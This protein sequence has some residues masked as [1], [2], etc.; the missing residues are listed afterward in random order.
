MVEVQHR[1][2]ELNGPSFLSFTVD[3]TRGSGGTHFV[4]ICKRQDILFLGTAISQNGNTTRQLLGRPTSRLGLGSSYWDV[5]CLM[6]NAVSSGRVE[7]L[8]DVIKYEF[9]PE[10]IQKWADELWELAN[11]LDQT[12]NKELSNAFYVVTYL[13]SDQGIIKAG[14]FDPFNISRFLADEKNKKEIIASLELVLENIDLT[15]SAYWFERY[16]YYS[17]EGGEKVEFRL[18]KYLERLL[19]LLQA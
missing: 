8:G 13:L 9:L 19:V 15:E 2:E 7:L 14:E 1:P 10:E 12:G 3:H 18:K 17:I 6:A 4:E 11:E 16:Q 5:E